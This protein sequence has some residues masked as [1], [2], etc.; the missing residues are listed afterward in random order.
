MFARLRDFCVVGLLFVTYS[1]AMAQSSSNWLGLPEPLAPGRMGS[2]VLHGGGPINDQVFERFIQLAGGKKARIVFVPS[3]G[4]RRGWYDSDQQMIANLSQRYSSWAELANRNQVESFQ[5]LFTD[6]PDDADDPDFTKPLET[7]TGVWFSGGDQL[8]LNYRFVGSYPKQTRFQR[9][10]VWVMQR[11]GVVGGTSAGMAAVPEIMT[12]WDER[13]NYDA[14]AA[15]VPGHGLGL[16]RQAIVEQHFD[17]RGGRLERF[18]SLLRDNNQLDQ[19]A[20]RRGAGI[21]MIGLAAE[22]SAALVV[23]GNRVEALGDANSHIFLKSADGRAIAWHQM[24]PGE[25]AVIER[26]P[27]QAAGLVRMEP[28][29]VR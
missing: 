23:Q 5:F 21:N 16:L 26:S 24:S 27:Q 29:F 3:A 7:A 4:F 11:G 8:R 12:L 17:A 9:G 6:D 28:R 22:E 25:S 2:L 13:A 1:A 18:T 10:L 19:L 14:P 20:G 15:V